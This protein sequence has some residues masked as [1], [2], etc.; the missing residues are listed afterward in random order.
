MKFYQ[1]DNYQA[2]CYGCF[3]RYR[4]R[5]L[6]L[7]PE[8]RVE[9]IGSSV[10]P[11]AISKGDLDIFVGVPAGEHQ[12]STEL[13]KSL[14]F[15]EKQDTLRTSELCMLESENGDNVA[16]QVVANGSTFE[17][18]LQFRD[19]LLQNP[20]LVEKYNRLKLSFEGMNEDSY[21]EAKAKFIESVLDGP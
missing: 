13:L 16:L 7:L 21:R 20:K 12:K 1:A 9:H 5:I 4:A 6:V 14:R 2:R 11:D 18:F 10:I 3:E 17:F 8:A 19:K 15:K